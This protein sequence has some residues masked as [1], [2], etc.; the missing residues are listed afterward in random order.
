MS[1]FSWLKGF[2]QDLALTNKNLA[3]AL[4]ERSRCRNLV[5]AIHHLRMKSTTRRMWHESLPIDGEIKKNIESVR[6]VAEQAIP[7]NHSPGLILITPHYGDFLIGIAG[8]A[9]HCQRSGKC[10]WVMAAENSSP[11]SE[12][13]SAVSRE[14]G[15]FITS[16]KT[17]AIKELCR[18]LKSGDC[19]VILTD[20][21]WISR[22]S[23]MVPFFGHPTILMTGAA[24]LSRH[25]DASIVPF[26]CSRRRDGINMRFFHSIIWP[27]LPD[28]RADIYLG[29]SLCARWLDASIKDAPSLWHLWSRYHQY[30]RPKL[31]Y[32][33]IFDKFC[34][35]LHSLD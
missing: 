3:L 25:C 15:F 32:P 17:M 12:K 10:L 33:E 18:K 7:L 4:P 14:L 21:V 20:S 19:A 5:S 27:E 11:L 22:S 28:K 24:W 34:E 13:F 2:A 8:I 9:A 35:A 23:R 1:T 31:L 30:T 26:L 16:S 29:T 6:V